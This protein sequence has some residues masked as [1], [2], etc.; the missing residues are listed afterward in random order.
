MAR[1][2]HNHPIRHTRFAESGNCGVAQIVEPQ[3][4]QPCLFYQRPPS[5][6]PTPYGTSRIKLPINLV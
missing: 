5:G 1:N 4:L 3:A 2:V 6:A